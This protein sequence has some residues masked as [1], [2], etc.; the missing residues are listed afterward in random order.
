MG[1]VFQGVD[2]ALS[3]ALGVS[4]VQYGA[5]LMKPI[6]KNARSQ[7][8]DEVA[9]TVAKTSAAPLLAGTIESCI[10]N[11][12]EVQR[13]FGLQKFSELPPASNA[14]ARAAGP[15]FV[16]NAARNAVMS[17]TSFVLTPL[18]YKNFFPQVGALASS[19]HLVPIWR[20]WWRRTRWW[21]CL[22]CCPRLGCCS[23][24]LLAA[25]SLLLLLPAG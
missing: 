16:A 1:L 9:R 6:D 14:L 18:V 19:P 21:W 25:S 17:S 24:F 4:R 22:G 11:R 2:I 23:S 5:Q 12:A 15:A 10:A 8:A 13:Y 3:S 20:W 7:S